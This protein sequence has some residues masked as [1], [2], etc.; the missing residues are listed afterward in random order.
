MTASVADKRPRSVPTR[1]VGAVALTSGRLSAWRRNHPEFLALLIAAG[2]WVLLGGLLSA[3]AGHHHGGQ[4]GSY[5]Q[6]LTVWVAMVPA[7][8]LPTTLPHLRYVGFATQ[9]ARTQRS[10][11]LFSLGYG[12]VWL[13]LGLVVAAVPQPLTGWPLALV[14]AAAGGWEVSR[15]KGRALKRCCRTWPVRYTG[16]AADASAV[17]FGLRHGAACLL[18]G[19]PAMIALMLAGHPWWAAVTLF[20][21][22]LGQKL[23]TAPQRWSVAVA[24][25]FAAVAVAVA[26]TAVFD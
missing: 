14:V 13:L 15:I 11:L 24:L 1:D 6:H 12:A 8:M 16:P 9:A 23:I 10:V 22:M 7:M 2:A 19:G 5:D 25:G 21:V 26:G 17:E 4:A 18:V 3:T 20:A